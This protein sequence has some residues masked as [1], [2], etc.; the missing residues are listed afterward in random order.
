MESLSESPLTKGNK[1]ELLI[2]G[3]ATY[4]A[5]F[6]MVEHV[7]TY[8]CPGNKRERREIPGTLAEQETSTLFFRT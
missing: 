7:P 2:D 1:V 3:P 6:K 8:H 4:A 5:M